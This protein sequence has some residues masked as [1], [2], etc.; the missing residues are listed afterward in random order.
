MGNEVIKWTTKKSELFFFN[1]FKRGKID[2]N[3]I[4]RY[5]NLLLIKPSF[6]R[7]L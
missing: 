7:N 1:N 2:I 4:I 3:T 6:G 5:E